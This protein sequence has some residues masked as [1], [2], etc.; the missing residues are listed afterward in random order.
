M[1]YLAHLFV[2]L[3]WGDRQLIILLVLGCVPQHAC[4]SQAETAYIAD[5]HVL[6]SVCLCV[7]FVATT[8]LSI[9]HVGSSSYVI[10]C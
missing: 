4:F 1:S 10:L 8:L 2:K 9:C 5:S 7:S 3:N 6:A